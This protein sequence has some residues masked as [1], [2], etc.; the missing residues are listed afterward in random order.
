MLSTKPGPKVEW[1][2]RPASRIRCTN[3]SESIHLST[4]FTLAPRRGIIDVVT[5]CQGLEDRLPRVVQPHLV[6]RPEIEDDRRQSD[7]AARQADVRTGFPAQQRINEAH[8]TPGRFQR[9]TV[10]TDHRAPI[11]DRP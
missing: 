2:R 11:N 8:L 1:T 6:F 4:H 9:I 7:A 10:E 5:D 3:W